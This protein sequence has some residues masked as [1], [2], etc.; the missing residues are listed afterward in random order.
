MSQLKLV[1]I[2]ID[3]YQRFRS[4]HFDVVEMK[5][6]FNTKYE[7]FYEIKKLINR[8]VKIFER[9]FVIQYLIR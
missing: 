5:N 9:I 1:S 3:S 4:S 6:V 8:R 7:K 2:D